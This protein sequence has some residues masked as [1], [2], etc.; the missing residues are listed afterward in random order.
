[1][2]QNQTTSLHRELWIIK[3]DVLIELC[4]RNYATLNGLV[5]GVDGI[6]KDYTKTLSKSLIWIHFQNPQIGINTRFE[7]S[8]TY[9]EFHGLDK[10]WTPIELKFVE[11]HIHC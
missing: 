10:N 8:Q 9:K 3:K 11:I 4:T 2:I 1:M 7:I 6:F 5:N